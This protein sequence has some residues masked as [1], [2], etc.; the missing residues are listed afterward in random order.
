GYASNGSSARCRGLA[1]DRSG[2]G[3]QGRGEDSGTHQSQGGDRP[4]PG[5]LCGDSGDRRNKQWAA[6]HSRI[7]EQPP[8]G[9][10]F[11]SAYGWGIVGT[12][13]HHDSG[14]ETIAQTNQ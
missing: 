4:D 1:R 10:E 3:W 13:G 8:E 7:G 6:E 2:P 5:G 9:Q 14:A 12:Q 11:G